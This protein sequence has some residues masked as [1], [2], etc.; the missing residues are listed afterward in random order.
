MV[1]GGLFL[2]YRMLLRLCFGPNI[3]H[4]HLSEVH[5]SIATA[6]RHTHMEGENLRQQAAKMVANRPPQ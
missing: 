3:R 1:P 6:Q 2:R 4:W 5:A